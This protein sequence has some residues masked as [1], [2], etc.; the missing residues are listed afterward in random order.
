MDY[1]TPCDLRYFMNKRPF[2]KRTKVT[3]KGKVK[4][5]KKFVLLTLEDNY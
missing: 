1:I 3:N 5:S 2:M 4:F